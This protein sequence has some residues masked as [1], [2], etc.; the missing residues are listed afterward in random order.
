MQAKQP[1]VSVGSRGGSTRLGGTQEVKWLR[2]GQGACERPREELPV[3]RDR[4]DVVPAHKAACVRGG[5]APETR[6]G[7]RGRRHARLRGAAQPLRGAQGAGL[8]GWEGGRV[9]LV[10]GKGRGVSGQYEERDEACPVSTGGVS[11]ARRRPVGCS[12][13]AGPRRTPRE[14]IGGPTGRGTSTAGAMHA[15]PGWSRHR[16]APCAPTRPRAGAPRRRRPAVR[17]E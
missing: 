4:R 8:S 1:T 15:R 13:G 17:R 7:A 11:T 2:G 10:R 12:C 16:R 6:S 9:R 3:E 5:A 14:A